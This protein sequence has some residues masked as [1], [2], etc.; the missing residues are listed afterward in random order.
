MTMK[1][2]FLIGIITGLIICLY[3]HCFIQKSNLSKII[4]SY[5]TFGCVIF[6]IIFIYLSLKIFHIQ[7]IKK[8][9]FKFLLEILFIG[10]FC[11]FY[12]IIIYY[13]RGKPIDMKYVIYLTLLFIF[14]HILLELCGKL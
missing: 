14:I 11:Y 2:T 12:F 6:L 7:F 10:I 13:F 9:L 5:I 8:S 3:I 1:M 4:D